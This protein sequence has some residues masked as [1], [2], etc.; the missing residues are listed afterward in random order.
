MLHLWLKAIIKH[1]EVETVSAYYMIK[2]QVTE[3]SA[4]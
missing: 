1:Y 3:I 2:F 4:L